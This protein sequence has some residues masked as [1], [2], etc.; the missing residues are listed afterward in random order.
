MAMTNQNS[1]FTVE[2]MISCLISKYLKQCV[3][4]C[5]AHRQGSLLCQ[6]RLCTSMTAWRRSLPANEAPGDGFRQ[7]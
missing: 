7:Q 2:L 5:N 4:R 3:W 1:D 6:D